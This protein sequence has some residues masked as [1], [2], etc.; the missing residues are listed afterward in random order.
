MNTGINNVALGSFAC[1]FPTTGSNNIVMGFNAGCVLRTG[2]NNIE[3]GHVG[4]TASESNT[5]RIGTPGTQNAM[6]LNE[7]LKEH[8]KVKELEATVSKLQVQGEEIAELKAALKE[9]AA[10]LHKVSARLE[11]NTIATRLVDNP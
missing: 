8:K 4:G 1:P 10:Q 11:A 2:S 9:H 7:F 3:I 5:I 6:L